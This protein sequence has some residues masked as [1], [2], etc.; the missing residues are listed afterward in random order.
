[1]KKWILIIVILLAVM[2]CGGKNTE[3]AKEEA[4]RKTEI[5]EGANE[6][7]VGSEKIK[8]EIKKKLEEISSGKT[9]DENIFG[10]FM[11]KICLLRI[12]IGKCMIE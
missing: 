4:D 7:N 3:K 8:E 5:K 2:S 6:K 12:P 9:S 1:M 11:L 10:K